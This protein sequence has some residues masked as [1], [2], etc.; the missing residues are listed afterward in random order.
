MVLYSSSD[1][2]VKLINVEFM[3]TFSLRFIIKI[4]PRILLM[5]EAIQL[6]DYVVMA[7]SSK[8]RVY[9]K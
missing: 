4:K 2:A 9:R 6:L 8:S 7:N 3:Q 5:V 1:A